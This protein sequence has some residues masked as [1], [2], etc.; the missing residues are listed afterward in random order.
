TTDGDMLGLFLERAVPPGLA[1]METAAEIHAQGGLVGL[2]HPFDRF[3]G[4]SGKMAAAEALAVLVREVDF[5]EVHNARAVG[6][7]NAQA[8]GG[9]PPPLLSSRLR[10][11]RTIISIVLP[12]LIL[13]LVFAAAPGFQL[14]RLPGLIAKANPWYLLA[15]VAV[16]YLGFPLRGYRWALLVRGA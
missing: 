13:V 3:R 5:I 9:A 4:S 16:Y 6:T 10:D 1:A 11:P 15:A 2:P 8:A 12:L 7:A 14:D